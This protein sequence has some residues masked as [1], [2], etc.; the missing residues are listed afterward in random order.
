MMV[1]TI[2]GFHTVGVS[3][4]SDIFTDTMFYCF[5]IGQCSIAKV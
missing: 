1:S 4:T 3:Q 5:V 2:L